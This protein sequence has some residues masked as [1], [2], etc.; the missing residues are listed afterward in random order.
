MGIMRRLGLGGGLV[1]MD[2]WSN[3]KGVVTVCC[4]GVLSPGVLAPVVLVS[5]VL[6]PVV[7]PP[8]ALP[9]FSC[10]LPPSVVAP[11]VLA[12]SVFPPTMLAPGVL[13]PGVLPPAGGADG[14]PKLKIGVD[15]TLNMSRNHICIQSVTRWFAL[16]NNVDSAAEVLYKLHDAKHS[17]LAA[18]RA[19]PHCTR[20]A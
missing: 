3:A 20:D 16:L 8:V 10:V 1:A 2:V 19:S 14:C 11:D 15:M 5:S 7:L 17:F 4:E 6:T 12:P 13:P 9:P 18:R